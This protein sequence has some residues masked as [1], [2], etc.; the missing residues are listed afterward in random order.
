MSGPDFRTNMTVGVK[1]WA[2]SAS[3]GQCS[4]WIFDDLADDVEIGSKCAIPAPLFK[5]EIEDDFLQKLICLRS[6]LYT[7]FTSY[8]K[9]TGKFFA[10]VFNKK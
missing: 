7:M 6:W 9:I 1:P 4:R 5:K 10:K 2:E 3:S 8:L